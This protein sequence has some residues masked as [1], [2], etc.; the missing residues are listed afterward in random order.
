MTWPRLFRASC[1]GDSDSSDSDEERSTDGAAFEEEDDAGKDEASVEICDAWRELRQRSAWQ[2]VASGVPPRACA[3]VSRVSR[4]QRSSRNAVDE[5]E[6]TA[7]FDECCT[8]LAECGYASS[9]AS[10]RGLAQHHAL[11]ALVQNSGVILCKT[12]WCLGERKRSK[13]TECI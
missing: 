4:V 12:S 13:E 11:A 3:R 1:V 9:G 7:L 10:R 6:A 5:R 8:A 2:S